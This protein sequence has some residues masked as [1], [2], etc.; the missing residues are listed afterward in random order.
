MNTRKSLYGTYTLTTFEHKDKGDAVYTSS[1][2]HV[3]V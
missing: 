1:Y 2:K 3:V